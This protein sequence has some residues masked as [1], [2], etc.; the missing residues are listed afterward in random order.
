[1]ANKTINE[2]IAATTLLAEDL[3][4]LQQNNVAKKI[5]GQTLI[6]ELLKLLNGRGG[7]KNIEFTSKAGLVDTYTITYA[8]DTTTTFTVTNGAKGDKGDT[9]YLYIRYSA[10]KPTNN[11]DIGTTPDDWIGIYVGASPTAPTDY[12]EY[13]WQY[14]KGGKGDKGDAITIISKNIGYQ[15]S[16]NGTAIPAGSWFPNIPAVAQGSFL[17]TR[18]QITFSTGE[19][20]TAY[21]V[22]RMGIDGKGAP[23]DELPHM[24]GKANPGVGENFARHDHVHPHDTS[25]QDT[26]M[27]GSISN[28]LIANNAISENKLNAALNKKIND[29][30]DIVKIWENAS[31]TSGFL[32]Q[33]ISL[34]DLNSYDKIVI[35]SRYY[36]EQAYGYSGA[37]VIID[38]SS[39]SKGRLM[40]FD[41]SGG[42][43]W[44]LSSRSFNVNT[45]G[46]Q[47]GG[48]YVTS[49]G[50]NS[51]N[52]SYSIPIVIYGVREGK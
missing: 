38:V 32:P 15:A 36:T 9:T 33:T 30:V 48:S 27:P 45:D 2:L 52:N 49:N 11:A 4:V 28:E 10:K 19:T 43:S 16:T 12:K 7:I 17:W 22:G 24:D 35:I 41:N 20:I 50:T 44:Y 37:P 25:K 23:S 14:V 42:S 8:N 26:L 6:N 29:K 3:L 5:S 21:S 47:F 46:V 40:N 1:M 18:T 31:P 13:L 34:G 51:Q 39:G